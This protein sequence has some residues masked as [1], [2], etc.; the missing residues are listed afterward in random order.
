MRIDGL[1]RAVPGGA[2]AM[3][4][5]APAGAFSLSE[6]PAGEPARRALPLRPAPALDA[7]IALQAM[8]DAPREKKR[9]QIARSRGLLDALDGLKLALINGDVDSAALSALAAGLRER[10]ETT[11]EDGLDDVLSAI[12]LRAQVEL[13]K[14]GG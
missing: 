3:A 4:R 11:G 7:L 9:R 8:P 1:G 10:G 14:R 2:A 13:A 5:G 6:P 12:E